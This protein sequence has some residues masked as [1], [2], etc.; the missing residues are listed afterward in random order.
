MA[1]DCE[2][3]VESNPDHVAA[4]KCTIYM[5]AGVNRISLGVQ[6]TQAHVLSFLGREH[7]PDHV[8]QAM[9]TIRQSGI[10]NINCDLIYGSAVETREDWDRTLKDV[11]SM[12]P[13]HISAYALGIEPG[14]P[15]GI[16]VARSIKE[17]TNEDDLADKYLHADSVL[18]DHGYE[19]Y[20][21]SNWSQPG[22]ESRHNQTY[23][24]GGD[25][26][27]LGCAAHS[28]INSKRFATP[29]NIDVYIEKMSSARTLDEIVLE[30]SAGES[31]SR[32]EETFALALRTRSGCEIPDPHAQM[33]ADLVSE[34]LVARQGPNAIALTPRGRLVAHEVAVA[35]FDQFTTQDSAVQ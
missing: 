25:V 17:A 34:G 12:E 23:W 20:E 1:P 14:T 29:R 21:I 13:Q 33:V 11:V 26:L 6:S 10:S 19:W 18:T 15:L 4:E 31:I 5:H 35:L 24:L 16:D 28:H 22:S 3:T 32:A 7:N 2:I 9:D 27:G 8:H 30:R